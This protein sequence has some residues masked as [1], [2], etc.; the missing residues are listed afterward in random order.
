MA[1]GLRGGAAISK[2]CQRPRMRRGL[3]VSVGATLV[4]WGIW[5]LKLPLPVDSQ[6][7]Q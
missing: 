4:E 5:I 7:S 3:W 1:A 6:D 2:M